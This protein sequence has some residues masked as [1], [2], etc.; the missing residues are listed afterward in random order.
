MDLDKGQWS[1]LVAGHIR[2]VTALSTDTCGV[3]YGEPLP[4]GKPTTSSIAI[5]DRPRPLIREITA[6]S[7]QHD[8]LHGQ[9]DVLTRHEKYEEQP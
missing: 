8:E 5:A 9:N 4:G 2:Y 7:T 3:F 1:Y 6:I